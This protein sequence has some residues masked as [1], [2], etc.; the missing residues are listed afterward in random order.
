MSDVREQMSEVREQMSEGRSQ[1]TDVTRRDPIAPLLFNNQTN[2]ITAPTIANRPIHDMKKETNTQSESIRDAYRVVAE[3]LKSMQRLQSETA[4]AHQKFLETQTEANRAL[5]EMM[6]STQRLTEGAIG[7]QSGSNPTVAAPEYGL[8]APPVLPP[9]ERVKEPARV[10]PAAA[11]PSRIESARVIDTTAPAASDLSIPHASANGYGEDKDIRESR[12]ESDQ[13]NPAVRPDIEATMLDI[14][15]RLTG[16]PLEMIGL[17]MDIEADLGIDSIKRVEILSNLEETIPDL[18]TVSPETMGSLKTLGQIV[19][20]M[21]QSTDGLS[22]SQPRPEMVQ[23]TPQAKTA[24]SAESADPHADDI[25]ATMLEVVSQLTGYPVE[26][27]GMDMDIEAELGIDSIKRVEILSNLEERMPDL[28]TVSPDMMGS[29]KTLGQ[30]VEFMSSGKTEN[31]VANQSEALAMESLAPSSAAPADPATNRQA[32]VTAKLLEVVSGL[33]GYPVEMLGL[34]MD[35]EAELGIDSI[36]RVEI[37]ST[38]EEKMPDLPAIAPDMIGSLKSLGQIAEYLAAPVAADAAP[39]APRADQATTLSVVAAGQTATAPIPEPSIDDSDTVMI[40]RHAVTVA[41]A[42][43]LAE[44]TIAV[45]STKKVFVT[46]DH[47]GLSEEIAEELAK[48]NIKTVRISLD[49]LKYKNRLPAAAGLIIVQDPESGQM[50]QDI[51]DAFALA[52]FLAPDLIASADGGAGAIFATVTRLDGAFGLKGKPLPHPIQGGLAGLVKTAA[53]EWDNVCCHAIDIAPDWSDKPAVAAAI[54][55]E[56]LSPGPIEIG[57][58]SEHRNALVLKPATRTAGSLNLDRK[59]VVVVSGGARGV[60]AEAALALAGRTGTQ[61]VL[62]GRSPEPFVEPAWLAALE[63]ELDI[64]KALLENEFS[65]KS[66]TPAAVDKVYHNYMAN[67]EIT[68][69]LKQLRSVASR[70]EYYSVDVRKYDKVA[71]IVDR[72]REELGPITGIIHGAGVLQDRLITDKTAEQF[73]R[74]Y[75]T[76][77]MGLNNLLQA[78]SRESLKYLVLFS[79]IAARLGNK[80]QVDY[81]VANEV[82][83]KMAQNESGNRNDCRVVSINWGPWDG[84]MVTAPLKREFERNGIHLI[85]VAYGAECMLDEMTASDDSSVEIV[86]GAELT[87]ADLPSRRVP[88]RP[89]LVKPA[90]AAKKQQLAL[91]FERQIDLEHYPILQSHIIDG[92]PVVPL[93]LMTEWLAHGALHENPGLLLHG[94]DDIRV[95]KGIRMEHDHKHIRLLTG[96]LQKLGDHYEVAVE[97]RDGNPS[98]SDM[99]H[100]TARAVLSDSLAEAPDY[101]FPKTMVAKA[102]NKKIKDVYDQI[103]FHGLQLHGIRKIVSCTAR[104]MVA[105]IAAAPAPAEW[106]SSPLR[107]QWIADPLV[108]DCAFQMATVWCFEEKGA[109]SLPSYGSSYRQYGEQFPADGVTVVLEIKDVTSRRMRGDFTVLDA[110]GAIVARLIGY[111]AIMDA[112]LFR[113]F[114]P[115]YRASA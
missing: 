97:L 18:P 8:P 87:K 33:T 17:D 81:A 105:H 108:L 73:D 28:P 96:K 16:Y 39:E 4:A 113:A 90:P 24:V 12:I 26:M 31:S 102:Y 91:S 107:N 71:A 23:T 15:S 55:K 82:L 41:A 61:L 20:F 57:L 68:S 44:N 110:E 29:L 13:P 69:N 62:L 51:K 70:V 6:K 84:G 100:A 66:P 21:N 1:L 86:I 50:H 93:A 9:V 76:K 45:P 59:D 54:V 103:L 25:K 92:K 32:A 7:I 114:K 10:E 89:E 38:L 115:E 80:G 112:S 77:V 30:I 75:D 34:D 79:S 19:E 53:L 101:R 27:L 52:K 58:D 2:S 78:T 36:K 47:T 72:I 83:N 63:D 14:V 99:I 56:V 35:I 85:P 60:T 94:L 109:V 88:K 98:G 65:D 42:P 64:K 43:P 22:D 95:M 5:Q 74:V 106:V 3:G 37:L 67:R 111:E 46:E 49:I 11:H 40:P 48:R 104:G